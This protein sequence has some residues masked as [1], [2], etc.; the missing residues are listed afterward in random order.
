[1]ASPG[2][3]WGLRVM[4]RTLRRVSEVPVVV[5]APQ[6]WAFSFEVND[7]LFLEVPR[8]INSKFKP[9]RTEFRETLTKL[10]MFSLTCFR[11]VT[12]IDA[13]CLFLNT[14]DDLFNMDGIVAGPDYVDGA[15]EGGFNTGLLSFEPRQ[16]LRDYVLDRAHQTSSCDAGDQGLL[17]QLLFS[18]VR[19]LPAEYDLMRHY[20][21]YAGP[22]L[23]R[24]EIKM[25]HYIVKKPWELWHREA[26]DAALVD[27]DD[28][29][30]KELTHDELL[31]L[32]GWWRRRQFIVERPRLEA[33]IAD[34][35]VARSARRRRN[36]NA[37][38]LG[39]IV[40]FLVSF[41][42]GYLAARGAFNG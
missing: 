28:L 40:V 10:W 33:L 41:V 4:L 39:A 42:L 3:E 15:V 29:W 5:F 12:F 22:E 6:R 24:T 11:R 16:A 32:V 37:V 36:R 26:P 1:L 2:Y 31:D 25:I 21:Y 30:T 9:R 13:D 27:L 35:V 14:I 34:P 38:V 18:Q 7:A 23:R 19:T 17:N 20:Y 8:I